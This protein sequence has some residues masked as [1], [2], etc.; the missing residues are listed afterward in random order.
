[1]WTP[2]LPKKGKEKKSRELKIIIGTKWTSRTEKYTYCTGQLYELFWGWCKCPK[3]G[4]GDGYGCTIEL[5]TKITECI[6]TMG[7][8][9]DM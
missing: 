4:F 1:M 5:M 6:Y 3:I 2:M 7:E 8:F 9:N